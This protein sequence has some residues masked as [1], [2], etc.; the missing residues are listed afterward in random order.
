MRER[1]IHD[2]IFLGTVVRYLQDAQPGWRIFD[3]PAGGRCILSNLAHLREELADGDLPVTRRAA[4]RLYLL[5]DEFAEAMDEEATLGAA[6]AARI[7]EAAALLRETLEAEAKG[8]MAFITT[9]KRYDAAHLMRDIARVFGQGVYAQLPDVAQYDFAEAGKCIAFER[10][11]AAAF[12]LLRGVEAALRTFHNGVLP[13]SRALL[14]KPAVD[15]LRAH[16]PPAHR[17]VLDHLDNIRASFR[18]P[19]QHPEKIYDVE[20]AQDLLALCVDVV[21]RMVRSGVWK[22]AAMPT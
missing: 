5:E 10:P 17:P 11:T 22:G 8:K 14:W 2:Y 20:E 19:T 4:W 18:N 3:A 15:E 13:A 21:N 9:E 7:R 12:H 6:G 16:L 1:S